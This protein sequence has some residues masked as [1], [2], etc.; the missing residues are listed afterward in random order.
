MS[1]VA[2][3]VD[4]AYLD[5]MLRDEF[6]GARID[7]SLL[8]RSLSCNLDILRTYYYHCLPYQGSPP[9][10]EESE[11][12]AKAESFFNSLRRLPRYEVR[13]GKIA[14]RGT[15]LEGKPLFVQKRVDILLGVDLVLLSAKHMITHAALIAGDSDFLPAVEAAKNEGVVVHL[16]HG[17][18]YPPHRDLWDTADERTPITQEVIN[19]ILR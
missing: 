1:R 17:T 16:H 7:Y 2:I 9:T 4:G 18:K 8:S 19:S 5:F 15:S 10:L 14:F 13:L 12:F 11:R 3:F 6:I